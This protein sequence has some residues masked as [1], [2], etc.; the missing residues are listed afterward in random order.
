MRAESLREVLNAISPDNTR[1]WEFRRVDKP[2]FQPGMTSFFLVSGP[3]RTRFD[4]GKGR[5]R[6]EKRVLSRLNAYRHE[7]R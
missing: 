5:F 2:R 3:D 7:F 4:L 6:G 1:F